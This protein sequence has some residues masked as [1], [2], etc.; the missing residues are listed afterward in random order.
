MVRNR[1][2][3]QRV[4]LRSKC[5]WVAA[6]VLSGVAWSSC[7]SAAES[8]G[9]SSTHVHALYGEGFKFQADKQATVTVEHFR[10]CLLYTSDAADE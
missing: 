2:R 9:F 7:A 1:S 5:L 8:G 3:F 6:L 4:I 10:T